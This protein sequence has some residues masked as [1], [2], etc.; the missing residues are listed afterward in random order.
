MAR[1][2]NQPMTLTRRQF[3]PLS[4]TLLGPGSA[5]TNGA[6]AATKH[7]RVFQVGQDLK[8]LRLFWQNPEG[9]NFRTLAAVHAHLI[10]Q[11][12]TPLMLMNSGI[13]GLDQAPLGLHVAEGKELRPVNRK[14]GEGNFYLMPN[15]IFSISA[16]GKS[17]QIHATENYHVKTPSLAV[18]SGPLLVRDGAIHAEFTKSS[19]HVNLRNGIGVTKDGSVLLAISTKPVNLHTFATTFRDELHCPNALYLD[20][21]ISQVWEQDEDITKLPPQSFVGI[22]AIVK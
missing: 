10:S 5:C 20:G 3:I 11:G 2:A 4:L 16:D 15:G 19:T 9:K 7:T 17:A 14:T 6:S 13:F 12:E 18:Q 22:L 21:H 8:K 1:Q